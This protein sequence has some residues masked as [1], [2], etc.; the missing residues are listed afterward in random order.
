MKT[1]YGKVNVRDI[2]V[3]SPISKCKKGLNEMFSSYFYAKS[4]HFDLLAKQVAEYKYRIFVRFSIIG[5]RNIY[6]R[7]G[8]VHHTFGNYGIK[9][10]RKS[11]KRY[12]SL[13]PP[14]VFGCEMYSQLKKYLPGG[15]E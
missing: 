5:L 14:K 13:L 7:S 6:I 15:G 4:Q 3:L 11:I 9:K 10:I 8:E 2:K 1:E 12:R